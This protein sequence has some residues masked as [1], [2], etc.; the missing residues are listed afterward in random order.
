MSDLTE[1]GLALL[2]HSGRSFFCLTGKFFMFAGVPFGTAVS[3]V[4]DNA[5]QRPLQFRNRATW[6][7]A[8][9]SDAVRERRPE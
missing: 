5:E 8:C 7:L 9:T 2:G 1:S 4:S 6:R 3:Y